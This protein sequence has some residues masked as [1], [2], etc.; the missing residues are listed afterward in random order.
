VI[1]PHRMVNSMLLVELTYIVLY[2]LESRSWKIADF[3]LTSEATSKRLVTSRYARGKPCYRAP[4]LLQESESRYNNK[5]D[6]WS[7]GCIMYEMISGQKPFSGDLAVYQYATSSAD[8]RSR[9]FPILGETASY[10]LRVFHSEE[11][12]EIDPSSRPSARKLRINLEISLLFHSYSSAIRCR[13]ST[14]ETRFADIQTNVESLAEMREPRDV[15]EILNE[16]GGDA[17]A[18]PYFRVHEESFQRSTL[19]RQK[20]VARALVQAGVDT[21]KLLLVAAF[22]RD[23]KFVKLILEAGARSLARKFEGLT[24]LHIAASNGKTSLVRLLLEAGARAS[25]VDNRGMTALHLAALNGHSEVVRIFIGS[26]QDVTDLSVFYD[27]EWLDRY[28]NL[29]RNDENVAHCL[30]LLTSRG[31]REGNGW[32]AIFN[33]AVETALDL[34]IAHTLDLFDDV[35]CVCFSCDGRYIASYCNG[36]ALVFEV[37]KGVIFAVLSRT[38]NAS[39]RRVWISRVCFSDDSMYLVTGDQDKCVTKWNIN[40]KEVEW[41]VTDPDGAA[42]SIAIAHD[43]VAVANKAGIIQILDLQSGLKILSFDDFKDG[44]NPRVAISPDGLFIAGVCNTELLLWET[45]SGRV[46]RRLIGP[47]AINWVT[48]SATGKEIF[49]A[50]GKEVKELSLSSRYPSVTARTMQH[51]SHVIQIAASPDGK[52]LASLTE[53]GNIEFWD[54]ARKDLLAPVVLLYGLQECW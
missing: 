29:W 21:R 11:L 5:V 22:M 17:P 47:F 34:S 42:C 9:S 36:N 44:Q 18:L 6:L 25:D 16:L 26:L 24:A 4:E 37:K 50:R 1:L 35:W 45:V 15:L 46:R 2:S 8:T 33:A 49:Y 23:V 40:E 53:K 12:L 20:M 31:K 54:L 51:E 13:F 43:K 52:W 38:F 27:K 28:N 3:G 48:F 41:Q 39:E 30:D 14:R 10:M 32:F 19:V 7:L